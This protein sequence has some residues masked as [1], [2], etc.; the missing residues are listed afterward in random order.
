MRV[1][2][3]IKTDQFDT[4]SDFLRRQVISDQVTQ[5][6][7]ERDIAETCGYDFVVGVSSAAHKTALERAAPELRIV[8]T[9]CKR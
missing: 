1:L 6:R 3:E 4:Y 2:W 8:V 9:E 7:E 5:M